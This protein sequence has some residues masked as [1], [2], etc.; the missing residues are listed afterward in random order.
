MLAISPLIFRAYDIRGIVGTEL[1]ADTVFSLGLAL[2]NRARQLNQ[3]QFVVAYD[4]RLSSPELAHILMD[5]L[6]ESGCDVINIGRVPTPVLYFAAQQTGHGTGVMITGSHNPPNY[7]GFKMLIGGNTLH[8]EE[9]QQ[10]YQSIVSHKLERHKKG[11][12]TTQDFAQAYLQTVTSKIKLQRPY[13]VVV[14]CGNGVAGEL[15]PRLLKALGCTVIPLFCEIDGHF[16]NH[17][18]D[19]MVPTNLKDLIRTVKEQHADIGLAF[20]GDGDRLGVVTETG[21]I[22]WPD[23]QLMLF[24]LDVLKKHPGAAIVFDVKCTRL[25]TQLIREQGGNPIMSQTGHSLI[26]AALKKNKAPLAGEMSGHIFFNDEWYGFDD[27]LY[28]AARLLKLLDGQNK[29]I[30]ELFAQFPNTISTPELPIPIAEDQKT[31]VIQALQQ[32]P[33]PNAEIMTIDGIRADFAKGWGLVRASN[34]TPTL[35][36]R[37]EAEDEKTLEEIKQQFKKALLAVAPELEIP[38]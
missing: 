26:K 12:Y 1:N 15:A 10:L 34:T 7:N 16:P 25:L 31:K 21:E 13:K 3:K 28:C 36:S 4:G 18:P 14:D 11:S 17:H 27:A 5:G 24:S 38:F 30:S 8:G 37:F 22:I 19:P 33:F 23:R 9:I 6:L 35:V 32:T 29:K 20:D 2:G